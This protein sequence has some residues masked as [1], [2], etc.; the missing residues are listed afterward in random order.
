M[1]PPNGPAAATGERG[2][3]GVHVDPLVIPG[4][5][6]EQV[7]LFLGD[8]EPVAVA[9]VLTGC[10]GQLGHAVE[11]SHGRQLLGPPAT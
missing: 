8:R 9:E 4:R 11:D 6:G 7:H 2:P 5:L 3:V 10:R 1:V